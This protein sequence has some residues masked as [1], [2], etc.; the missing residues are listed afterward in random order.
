MRILKALRILEAAVLEFKTRSIDS[1]EV[2]EALDV[3]APLVAQPWTVPTF[4]RNLV[5]IT[6]FYGRPEF[7]GQQQQLRASFGTIH[8]SVRFELERY[9]GRLGYRYSRTRKPK[10]WTEI[11][12]LEAELAKLPAPWVF[13]P[14][15]R[16]KQKRRLNQ[17]PPYIRGCCS[18][19]RRLRSCHAPMVCQDDLRRP[20]RDCRHTLLL[21]CLQCTSRFREIYRIYAAREIS[22]TRCPRSV[23]R[24]NVCSGRAEP[25]GRR[26]MGL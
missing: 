2:R 12:R 10:L 7:E 9:L 16:R 22:S 25:S 6:G 24:A 5:P 19:R 23:H 18:G 14:S 1:P 13:H 26:R 3:V 17:G 11:Q 21:A 15:R 8:A 4:R 20:S